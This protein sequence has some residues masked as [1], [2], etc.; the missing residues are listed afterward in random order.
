MYGLGS[1]MNLVACAK[2][3]G[4][5]LKHVKQSCFKVRR[6]VIMHELCV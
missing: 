5:T 6:V 1:Q 3:E 2:G 4:R